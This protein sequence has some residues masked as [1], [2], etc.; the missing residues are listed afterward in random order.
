MTEFA[1][2]KRGVV[3]VEERDG[4]RVLIKRRNP[5]SAIDTIANEAKFTKLLNER[6]IGPQFI[7]YENGELVR[8]FVDGEELRDWL[9]KATREEAVRVLREVL[10]QCRVMDRVGI[11]KLEMTRPWKHIL[12]TAGAPIMIDFERC[13]ET[14]TPKNVT[15]F[16]QFL[17][18]TAVVALLKAKGVEMD[19]GALRELAKEYKSNIKNNNHR[20]NYLVFDN[21]VRFLYD[22]R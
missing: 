18:S 11:D 8:E 2:G 17:T 6:D 19:S 15:Q 16:V 3:F 5:K 13:R 20:K 10:R 9:P 12:I 21:I 22:D 14:Q 4:Q 1:H 7:S